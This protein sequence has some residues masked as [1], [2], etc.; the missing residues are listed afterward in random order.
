MAASL[1]GSSAVSALGYLTKDSQAAVKDLQVTTTP[2]FVK[3]IRFAN[4]SASIRYLQLH[5]S[6]STPA[7]TAIP[8]VLPLTI[9]PGE[10]IEWTPPQPMLFFTA[11]YACSSTTQNTKTLTGTADMWIEADYVGA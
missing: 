4:Q 9:N 2:A 8:Y 3:S 6:A 1:F 7:D 10:V 5:N 11:I